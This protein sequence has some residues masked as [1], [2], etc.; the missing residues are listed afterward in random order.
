[1]KTMMMNNLR[2][3]LCGLLFSTAAL[4]ANAVELSY[5]IALKQP[6]NA[7]VVHRLAERDGRLV[8]DNNLPVTINKRTESV[9]EDK[10]LSITIEA[11]ETTY[12]N[13][14]V[15]AITALL[16]PQRNFLNPLSGKAFSGLISIRSAF[17]PSAIFRAAAA[18]FPLME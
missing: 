9:G 11:K 15:S 18:V 1:M 5:K 10:M 17:I 4:N 7:A 14:G 16:P 6:G 2:L 12:F 13:M 8:A 3:C